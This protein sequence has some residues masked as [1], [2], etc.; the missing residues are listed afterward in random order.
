MRLPLFLALFFIVGVTV[1]GMRMAA[2]NYPL[3]IA[4][5][6]RRPTYIAVI[7]VVNAALALVPVALGLL[8]RWIGYGG[9]FALGLAG[10]LSAIGAARALQEPRSALRMVR[11]RAGNSHDGAAPGTTPHARDGSAR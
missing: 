9:V 6:M 4:P 1:S 5:E 10:A 2:V 11:R 8:L 3:E 7:S